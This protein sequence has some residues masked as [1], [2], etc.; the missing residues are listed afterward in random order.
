MQ[1]LM[2]V[3]HEWLTRLAESYCSFAPMDP[4]QAPRYDAVKDQI[5][6]RVEVTFGPLNWPLKP[7]D[8]SIPNDIMLYRYFAQFLLAGEVVPM[9][10]EYVPKML[11]PPTTMVRS[12]AKLQKRTETL[13]NALVSKEIHTKANLIAEW[14]KMRTIYSRSI[15][16]GY[17]NHCIVK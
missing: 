11:A 7:V 12:W 9:L 4:E 17:L 6:T 3:D 13:L 1:V 5:V 2:M 16:N 10:A 8:R 14:H 15:W